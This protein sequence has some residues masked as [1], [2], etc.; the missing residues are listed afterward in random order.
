MTGITEPRLGTLS[1]LSIGIGGMV[2][3]GVFA[4]TFGI[5]TVYRGITKRKIQLIGTSE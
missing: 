5:E 4:V 1:T 3:G 2:G